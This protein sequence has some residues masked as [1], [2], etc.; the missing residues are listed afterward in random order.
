MHQTAKAA[1][2]RR[3]IRPYSDLGD[4]RSKYDGYH[5][6]TREEGMGWASSHFR[7]VSSLHFLLNIMGS[8]LCQNFLRDQGAI[9]YA[10]CRAQRARTGS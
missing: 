10:H 1:L 8:S 3:T 4:G 7:F 9:R 6:A 2:F 5:A